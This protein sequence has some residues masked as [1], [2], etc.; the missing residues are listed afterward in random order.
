MNSELRKKIQEGLPSLSRIQKKLASYLIAHWDEIPLM[1]IEAISRETRVSTATITRFTR[2]FDNDGFYAFKT[3]IR[4][5]LKNSINPINRFKL[6]RKGISGRTSIL[7]VA[8]QDVKNI[9][10][11]LAEV[12]EKLFL[13]TVKMIEEA[14][15][16]FTF[17]ASISSVFAGFLRYIFNQVEKETH[18]L[19][20]SSVSVEERLIS[21]TTDDLVI[22]CSFFPYSRSTVEYA[23]LG[24]QQ[25]LKIISISDNAYSPI[26]RFSRLVIPLP[27]ENV[28]FT[29]SIA[30]FSVLAN[31]LA[32]EI[33]LKKKDHLV[34]KI[35]R[36]DRI[37]KR[38][39][40]QS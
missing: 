11:F 4:E 6:L 30:A 13:S 19:D 33:A 25:G 34:D 28:L 12:D 24:H 20:E 10:R 7:K 16:V 2:L 37:L 15:R 27:R 32:T 18:C 35:N 36:T 21:V 1:S 5:E 39:H 23:Q 9:N 40:F 8:R 29:T 38:F 14:R 31:A 26:S 22:F 3:R 17:G